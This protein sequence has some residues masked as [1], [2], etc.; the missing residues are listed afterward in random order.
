M[1]TYDYQCRQCQ[2]RFE[3]KHRISDPQPCCTKCGGACSKLI[4]TAPA[5]HGVMAAGREQAI[6]ALQAQH[7]NNAHR[8]G[9]SCSCCRH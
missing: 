4:L 2:Y 5:T 8:H 3:A 6:H 9:P 1:P 7:S